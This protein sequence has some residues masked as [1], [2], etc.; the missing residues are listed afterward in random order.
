MAGLTVGTAETP[1]TSQALGQG[2][3]AYPFTAAAAAGDATAVVAAGGAATRHIVTGILVDVDTAGETLKITGPTNGIT[4]RFPV[5]DTYN[6]K[7]DPPLEC[8]ANTALG[9]DK[10]TVATVTG[11]IYVKASAVSGTPLK[12]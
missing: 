9:L 1:Y 10:G 11:F 5:A 3:V 8:V 4:L 6:L 12:L 2:I 7:F